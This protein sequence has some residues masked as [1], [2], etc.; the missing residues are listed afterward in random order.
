MWAHLTRRS[1]T[2]LFRVV[3][4]LGMS[5]TQ[6]KMLFLLEDGREHSLGDRRPPQPV[7][8]AASRAVDGLIQRAVVTRRESAEDRRSRLIALSDHG[9][10]VVERMVRARHQTLDMF[11]AD[12]TPEERDNLLA[13]LLPIVERITPQ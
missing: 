3:D 1:S 5:F 13:A 6:V 7:P 12:I 10:E 4:E 2:D 9:R 8:P 11:V